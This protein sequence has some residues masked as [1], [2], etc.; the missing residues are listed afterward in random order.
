MKKLFAA[1]LVSGLTLSG[2]SATNVEAASGNSIQSVEQ[3]EQGDQELEGAELGASIETVLENN[4]KPLYSYSPDGDEH[5]Y[6][7]KKDN[8]VLVVTADGKK[9]NGKII[10][11]SM[12]Y[13]DTNGPSYKEVK[14]A[15]SN[16]AV[17]REH[18]NKVTGNFGYVQDNQVSYQFSSPSPNDKNIKLYR[19]DISK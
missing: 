9:N 15:V 8:G 2:F 1:L 17:A 11:V 13:N 10:R 4:K 3:L 7:F 5:Y 18:Y 6:E 19:I 16:Q 14:N 12:S